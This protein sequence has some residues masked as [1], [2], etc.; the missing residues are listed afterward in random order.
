MTQSLDLRPGPWSLHILPRPSKSVNIAAADYAEYA[1]LII[2]DCG[3]QFDASIVARAARGRK[4]ITDRIDVQRAFI[5]SEV[6]KLVEETH[7]GKR[8]VVIL[9]LLST[10]YDENV[11]MYTRK[12]FL[13][14]ILSHLRRLSRGAGLA[15]I[16]PS[17]P[18]SF[19]SQYLFG[20]L[21]ASAP[22][23]VPYKNP[24]TSTQQLKLF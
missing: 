6:A 4:E 13:E 1:P 24:T 2:L 14:S 22:R 15:V 18:D 12:F 23:V 8:P 17:P 11:R 7:A 19:D 20:R 5:C 16:V 10:F 9:D 21:L 3:R